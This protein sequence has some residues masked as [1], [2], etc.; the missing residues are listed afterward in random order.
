MLEGSFKVIGD[1]DYFWKTAARTSRSRGFGIDFQA[2]ADKETTAL[3]SRQMYL[4][5][6]AETRQCAD[7]PA[8]TRDAATDAP[9]SDLATPASLTVPA[10]SPAK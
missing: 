7:D 3:Q 4:A 1:R 6:L 2:A 8:I 5:S 10:A 9:R